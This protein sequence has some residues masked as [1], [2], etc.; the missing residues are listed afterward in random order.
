[1]F[2]V[3]ALQP[4]IAA[5]ARVLAA[6]GQGA[7][8]TIAGIAQFL[9]A[10][11]AYWIAAALALLFFASRRRVGLLNTLVSVAVI[12]LVLRAIGAIVRVLVPCIAPDPEASFGFVVALV[13]TYLLPLRLW[14]RGLCL[15]LIGLMAATTAYAAH[16]TVP[17]E[18]VLAVGLVAIGVAILWGLGRWRPA[19]AFYQRLSLAVDNWAARRA[20]V[21]LTPPL[22]AVLAARLRQHLG[23]T[24]LEM[25]P[26]GGVGVHSSTPLALTG[27]DREGRP[28]RY[29]AKIVTRQNWQTSVLYE[30]LYRLVFRARGGSGPLWPSLKSM[31]EY[32]H[33]MLL[34]FS[35]LG[36]P[37]PRPWGVYR[38]QRQAYALVSDYMEG[39]QSLREVGQVSRGYV[40][41][42]FHALRRLREGDCAHRDVKSS[43][44][45]VL[46][47]ERFAMV[48]LAL[49]E[50]VAGPKRLARDLADMLAVL[51][52][53]HDPAEVV[54]VAH[55]IVGEEG[56]RQ[57]RRYVHRSLL[58][59]ETQKIIPLDLPRE[60]RGLIT[61]QTS[62]PAPLEAERE[63]TPDERR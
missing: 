40:E 21:P 55:E 31:V 19:R 59:D 18:V 60:L 51:A 15:G 57:A 7:R 42:A 61:R 44:L 16:C 9:A 35:G 45:V 62:V 17:G 5:G 63:Q 46:P 6:P 33:Y 13:L 23:F 48:D 41:Q 26:V 47:G 1:M 20:R 3:A 52:M 8:P 30:A 54:A 50:Y 2:P 39:V 29:F 36:A 43:N 32:E 25:Q 56:L 4:A 27:T 58:N 37:V 24:V 34:L 53:H 11:S 10:I 12:W 38:L 28:R 14:Q 49:A 22:L